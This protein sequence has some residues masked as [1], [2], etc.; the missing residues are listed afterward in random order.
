MKRTRGLQRVDNVR[1]YGVT[2]HVI[3]GQYVALPRVRPE[4]VLR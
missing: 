4:G 1:V 2:G 3:V